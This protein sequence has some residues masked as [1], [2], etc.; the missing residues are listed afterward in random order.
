MVHNFIKSSNKKCLSDF[1]ERIA[2]LGTTQQTRTRLKK[3]NYV[4]FAT[5]I[6][7]FTHGDLLVYQGRTLYAVIGPEHEL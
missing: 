3:K 2:T 1:N 6:H 7:T 4:M 5:T